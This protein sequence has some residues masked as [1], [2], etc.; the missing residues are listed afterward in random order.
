MKTFN[1]CK[2]ALQMSVSILWT[3]SS[4][5]ERAK[6]ELAARLANEK[7]SLPEKVDFPTF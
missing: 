6:I 1:D 4:P 5:S 2:F 7:P 3:N